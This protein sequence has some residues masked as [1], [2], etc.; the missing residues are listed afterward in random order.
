MLPTLIALA[1]TDFKR[2]VEPFAGSACLFFATHPPHALLGDVNSALIET[3]EILRAHPRKLARAVQKLPNTRD[4][5]YQIRD[6]NPAN[7]TPLERATRFIYLNRLCFN[8]VY[9]TNR[10]GI[11]NVPI[12]SHQGAAPS[13]KEF[14]RCSYA[15]RSAELYSG[16]FAKCLTS[17]HE[18]D[19]V[20]LDP[21]YSS[22]SRPRFGEYGYDTFQPIDIHRLQSTLK[23]IDDVGARFLLSYSDSRPHRKS[24]SAWNVRSLR[25]RRHVAGFSKHRNIVS[26]LLVSNYEIEAATETLA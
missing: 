7:M 16:D 21:P 5:Y 4:K 6:Q 19:F 20:Y 14:F 8:G 2:Y 13:E 22:S 24:F 15:L 25:V 9:R 12:G 1:P 10:K 3:Y 11:F 17:L 18:S 26:E 23:A